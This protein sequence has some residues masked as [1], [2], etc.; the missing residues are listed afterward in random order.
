METFLLP[1]RAKSLQFSIHTHNEADIEAKAALIKVKKTEN[2]TYDKKVLFLLD[3]KKLKHSQRWTK[4]Y[5]SNESKLHPRRKGSY[6]QCILRCLMVYHCFSK[7]KEFFFLCLF[8]RVELI[9]CLPY[10]LAIFWLDW[11]T[12][13]LQTCYFITQTAEKKNIYTHIK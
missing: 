1:F 12:K 9:V 6:C 10:E 3:R 13:K 11:K 2:A 5:F 8:F 7:R 4:E